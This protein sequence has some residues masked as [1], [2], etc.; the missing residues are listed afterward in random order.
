LLGDWKQKVG[1]EEKKHSE[2]AIFCFLIL[3][4]HSIAKIRWLLSL[5]FFSSAY[6]T[7][8]PSYSLSN[9]NQNLLTGFVF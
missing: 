6:F 7:K 9:P 4:T 8:I 5:L 3:L 2:F 1:G